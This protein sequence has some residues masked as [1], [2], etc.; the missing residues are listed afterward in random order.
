MNAAS[1]RA[2]MRRSALSRIARS[3]PSPARA[4]RTPSP[5]GSR[6]STSAVPRLERADHQPAGVVPGV[7]GTVERSHQGQ[8]VVRA[9]DR[10]RGD[11]DVFGGV[12]GHR[13]ADGRGEVTGPQAARDDDGLGLDGAARRADARDAPPLQEELLDGDS[14]ADRDAAVVRALRERE[15][16]VAG[17]HGPVAGLEQPADEPVGDRE[18]PDLR[19]LVRFSSRASIPW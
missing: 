9:F 11:V 7:E 10:V 6:R 2:G 1:F 18:R 13:H 16:R 8:Q 3:A 14:F 19:D 12:E 15:R 5:P 17:V 4:R